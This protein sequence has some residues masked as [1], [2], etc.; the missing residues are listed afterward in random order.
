MADYS[1]LFT[2]GNIGGLKPRNRLVMPPMVRNYADAD[3]RVT[4]RYLAHIERIARGGVGTM[5][6]E[7]SYVREDGRGF[8]NE[9]GLHDDA[10]IE[11][12]RQLVEA[13][14][15]HDVV[16]GIQL[17]HGG[18][19]ASASVSGHQ[20]VAPSAIADPVVNELP[21]ALEVGEIAELVEAFGAAARR[22]RA[23]GFDFVEIH[24]AHGYLIDAFLSA[25][26]NHREDNY[27]GSAENRRR[28]LEEVFAA[29]RAATAPDYPIT[30]RLSADE[31]V[32]GGISIT[33]TCATAKR[34]ETLGAAALHVSVGNYASYAEGYM[35]AP[36]ARPDG[37]L[38]DLAEQVKQCVAIPVIAVGK[39]RTPELAEQTLKN[40]RADFIALGRSLLADPDWP[41]KALADEADRIRH[42]VACNQGCIGRL[43]AQEDVWCTVNPETGREAAFADL[44]G[45]NG[46]TLLVV[47]GGPAGMAAARYGALAGFRVEL[48]E[49]SD[50]LGGQLLAAA[51]APHRQDWQTLRDYLVDEVRRL[52]VHVHL[53]T[54]VDAAKVA[55]FAPWATVVATG[56]QPVR[57][58]LPH[59]DGMP[60][61]TGRDVLLE[62]RAHQGHIVVAGGGC[63]GAQTAEY[64][65]SCGH[66]VTIVEATPEVAVDAPVDDRALLLE[67]L[68]Q[69]GVTL[70]TE[71]RLAQVGAKSITVA[72][73]EGAHTLPADM[74]VV[75]L[76]VRPVDELAA[77]LRSE[78]LRYRIVG[79]AHAPRKVTEGIEEGALAILDLL[80]NPGQMLA[81]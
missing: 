30:V 16:M 81:A 4:P 12:L 79:D 28:F 8:R 65:A 71:S 20:P 37:L 25:F 3:G 14:H 43:F 50:Q 5:I 54:R 69:H 9:L 52:G 64:L 46:R 75:C 74:L 31:M 49:A 62:S 45:G 33:E 39:L 15:R 35:I 70:L 66:Q 47:G 26:S 68:R 59:S 53:N 55:A 60:V 56:S 73:P 57:P 29:V 1:L 77:V 58:K 23:A 24:G 36:M 27:G 2:P 44:K 48:C 34:L 76:G 61:V 18:R 19:Q 41:N 6:I 78:G 72:T 38:L 40:G 7:A 42:C 67:R 17:Y 10:V 13:G 11:P 51:V 22:A 32:P 63:S 21:H 80:R